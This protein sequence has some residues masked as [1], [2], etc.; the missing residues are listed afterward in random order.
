MDSKAEAFFYEHGGY[1]RT[2]GETEEQGRRRSA[3]ESQIAE[4]YAR[5]QGW[6]FEWDDD[7]DCIG[8]ECGQSDCPCFV[9]GGRVTEDHQPQYCALYS[10]PGGDVLASLS[11]ICGADA[12]YRRVVQAELAWEAMPS[13]LPVV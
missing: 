1:S 10:E 12:N 6:Y 7:S 8:C 3:K 11:G 13:P 2:Q 5:E 9:S 4:E